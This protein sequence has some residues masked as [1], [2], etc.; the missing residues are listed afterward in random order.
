MMTKT[1]FI[2]GTLG[3]LAALPA[4]ASPITFSISAT[5][6]GTL[7]GVAFSNETITFT[8]VTNTSD[9]TTTCFT[10]SYPCAP[11]QAGNTVTVGGVGYTIS[12]DTYFF[13]NSI[14]VAGIAYEPYQAYLSAE[15]SSPF[16][17]YGLTTA[18]ASAPYTLYTVGSTDLATSGGALDIT[19]FSGEAT[20]SAVLGSPTS[21]VPEPGSLGLML[22]GAIPLAALRMRRRFTA[23]M[24]RD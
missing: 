2:L 11:D 20:F 6:S 10:Y 22:A 19:S 8:E 7:D 16:A 24:H 4:M 13:D 1:L 18:L 15:S 5:G 14:N 21:A 12:T 17:T 9:I 23:S 3:T